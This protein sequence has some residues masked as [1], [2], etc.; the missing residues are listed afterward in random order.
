MLRRLGSGLAPI[1]L[2]ILA[3][4]ANAPDTNS[5]APATGLTSA[6]GAT[7]RAGS[8]DTGFL[9]FGNMHIWIVSVDGARALGD[10]KRP[11][12]LAPGTHTLLVRSFRD[13][14]LAYACLTAP[15]EAGKAY[16][17]ASTKVEAEKT[18]LWIEDAATGEV[19]GEK[20]DAKTMRQPVMFG[21]GLNYL[22]N[23]TPPNKC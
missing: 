23:G 14:V 18:T 5:Y 11:V 22:I 2:V 12:L 15:F 16:V 10:D 17:A 19:V 3:A 9:F 6:T 20:V 8:V 21:P 13:P 7:L 4:C 1:A